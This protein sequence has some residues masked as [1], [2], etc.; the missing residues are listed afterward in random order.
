MSQQL[1]NSH[2]RA[3]SGMSPDF[4]PE[5]GQPQDGL[6]YVLKELRLPPWAIVNEQGY[7]TP[8]VLGD[9]MA[10][11]VFGL[12]EKFDQFGF[13]SQRELR[14]LDK[15]IDPT[16]RERLIAETA[17]FDPSGLSQKQIQEG[18][19]GVDDTDSQQPP[20]SRRID[21]AQHRQPATRSEPNSAF[22]RRHDTKW[23]GPGRYRG[24]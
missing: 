24:K 7:Y 10:G 1:E 8:K 18:A 22:R 3:S 19:Y 15:A 9:E 2:N 12:I 23:R 17:E 11:K 6:S 21:L 20:W 13:R 14:K 16:L 5:V 4:S